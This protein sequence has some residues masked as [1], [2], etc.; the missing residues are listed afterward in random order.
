MALEAVLIAA[1]L[2]AHLAVPFELLQALGLDAV[3]D[4]LRRQKLILAHGRR[5][6]GSKEGATAQGKP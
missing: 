4:S 1:L 2:L 5:G 3:G 6:A